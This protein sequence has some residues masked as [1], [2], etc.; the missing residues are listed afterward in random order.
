MTAADFD[1]DSYTELSL[2]RLMVS[3]RPRTEAFARA[4]R[5]VVEEGQ[6]VID[7]GAGTGLLAMLA[8]KAG[9]K[10]VYGLEQ[11]AIAFTA[12]KLVE[13]N[14]LSSLVE[15]IQK[16]AA[17]FQA[18]QAV[19]LIV[20]EW[21]GHFAFTEGMLQ[22]VLA[23]RD[24]NLKTGG[25]MLPSGVELLLA[26][27]DSWHLYDDEGPGFWDTTIHGI[28]FSPLETAEIEQAMGIKTLVQPEEL[29]APGQA[30]VTLDLRT[31]E[32]EEIWQRGKLEFTSQRDGHLHGFAGWF[33]AQL[34][35]SVYLSTAP[36]QPVTHWHQTYLP[37]RPTPVE[38]GETIR[39]EY[40]LHQHPFDSTSVEL[41]L[42][43]GSQNLTFMIT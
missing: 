26:P 23:C 19:D 17:S 43:T 24:T 1:F 14:G 27:L 42:I 30:I 7:V 16:N 28:D 33:V 20:S 8:A 22:K 35:P 32:V 13:S 5:E 10:K 25:K 31:A 29:L 4:I 41:H 15:V 21:I 6:Q 11:A 38:K 2:Q 40:A 39:L 9:A 12:R 37:V 34:S 18:P 3:D 36:D